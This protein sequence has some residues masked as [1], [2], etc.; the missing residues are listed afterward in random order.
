MNAKEKLDSM[1]LEAIYRL[2]KNEFFKLMN[3]L[4]LG[5]KTE[6]ISRASSLCRYFNEYLIEA[7]RVK[8]SLLSSDLRM[9]YF[10]ATMVDITKESL[11]ASMVDLFGKEPQIL[12]KKKAAAYTYNNKRQV[13]LNLKNFEKLVDEIRKYI[14]S[15]I[16]KNEIKDYR[17]LKYISLASIAPE[18]VDNSVETSTCV[19]AYKGLIKIRKKEIRAFFLFLYLTPQF[20]FEPASTDY[21]HKRLL[22]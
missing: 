5:E 15:L 10:N 14:G 20:D 9:E 3:G 1:P 11:V 13:I 7:V 2:S 21:F 17:L 18:F 4:D 12:W 8:T 6:R 22:I 19:K 16:L